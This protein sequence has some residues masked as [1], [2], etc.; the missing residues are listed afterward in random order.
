[1]AQGCLSTAVVK[2]AAWTIDARKPAQ[3]PRQSRPPMRA[4]VVRRMAFALV[5][6]ACAS[7]AAFV[8]TRAAAGDVTTQ[9]GAFPKPEEVAATRARFGLDR[10]VAAQWLAWAWRAL[11]FDFGES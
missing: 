11:R 5:L 8:L 7:S 4:F 1:M 2:P 3:F 9:L 10:P 6:V